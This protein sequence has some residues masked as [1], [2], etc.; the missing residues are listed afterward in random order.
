[1]LGA[2]ATS[3]ATGEDSLTS[4]GVAIRPGLPMRH[5][6][7]RHAG[8]P[9]RKSRRVAAVVD[10]Y[11]ERATGLPCPTAL[12]AVRSGTV[13]AYAAVVS[14]RSRKHVLQ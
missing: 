5:W 12:R 3:N 13:Q 4:P 6:A 14:L 11:C 7:G 8:L 9:L 2:R 1:M 10:I